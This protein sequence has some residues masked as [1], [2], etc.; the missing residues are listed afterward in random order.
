ML[1]AA[2][3]YFDK[4]KPSCVD[5]GVRYEARADRRKEEIQPLAQRRLLEMRRGA[6]QWRLAFPVM[7]LPGAGDGALP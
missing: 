1:E 6:S 4:M 3:A 7:P 5:A 2:L